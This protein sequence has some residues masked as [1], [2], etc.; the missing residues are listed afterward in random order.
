MAVIDSMK[1]MMLRQSSKI[2]SNVVRKADI[3]QLA[4]LFGHYLS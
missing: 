2:V 1:N 3:D 4:T